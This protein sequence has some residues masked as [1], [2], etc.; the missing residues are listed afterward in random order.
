MF[1]LKEVDTEMRKKF[2]Q[3]EFLEQGGIQVLSDWITINPDSTYPLVQVIELVFDI[4]ENLPIDS[5]HLEHSNIAKIL[6]LYAKNLCGYPHLA[7]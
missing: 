4:L 7:N 2:I 6:S 3:F 1:L 5:H